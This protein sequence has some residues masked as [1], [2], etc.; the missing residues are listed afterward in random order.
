MGI[1]QICQTIKNYF[2]NTRPPV[3]RIPTLL[4]AC[5]LV[6]RPGLSTITSVA[7]IVK[8]LNMLCINTGP[9]PDGSPNLTVAYTYAVVNE[10]YRALKMDSVVQVA[11]NPN[12]INVV[13]GGNMGT[14]PMPVDGSGITR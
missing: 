13:V 1:S 6:K 5:S 4:L 14:N 12:S 9:M 7:N 3:E 11:I 10:I 8:D 2:S